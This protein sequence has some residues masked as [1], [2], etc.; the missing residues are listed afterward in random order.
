MHASPPL[1]LGPA[2]FTSGT[3]P[4]FSLIYFSSYRILPT[5]MSA[6]IVSRTSALLQ[7][8]KNVARC[9]RR[10]IHASSTLSTL[11]GPPDPVSHL[12]PVIYDESAHNGR[13]RGVQTVVER[14]TT[15]P[16]HPYS[17]E[18]FDGD[19]SDYQWKLE[20]KRLDAYN[21][22]FWTD[23]RFSLSSSNKASR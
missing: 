7:I 6:T 4:I 21:H 23:V 5:V 2:H 11:V 15:S 10:Q 1:L 20:R 9:R 22:T 13:E 12:R 16:T 18:E 3:A 8:T 17:L 19:P 14:A